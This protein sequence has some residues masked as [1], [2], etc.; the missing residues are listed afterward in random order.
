MR[1]NEAAV[2]KWVVIV[3]AVV[4]FLV[5][6]TLLT[7]RSRVVSRV[8][9][10]RAYV[11][12]AICIVRTCSRES[13]IGRRKS[14]AVGPSPRPRRDIFPGERAGETAED[15]LVTSSSSAHFRNR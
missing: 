7:T 6:V 15:E 2:F 14:Y 4:A 11:S 5:A 3:G 1:I 13:L 8:P 10:L 12:N 9:Q